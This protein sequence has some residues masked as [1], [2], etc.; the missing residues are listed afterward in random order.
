MISVASDKS[1]GENTGSIEICELADG[2]PGVTACE[3]CNFILDDNVKRG[4]F[5]QEIFVASPP[6]V[7]WQELRPL[8]RKMTRTPLF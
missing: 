8:F 1:E 4:P 7:Q 6:R 5:L 2:A 3:F